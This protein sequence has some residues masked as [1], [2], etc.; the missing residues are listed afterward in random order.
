[1]RFH[2]KGPVVPMGFSLESEEGTRPEWPHFACAGDANGVGRG[3][4]WHDDERRRACY[5]SDRM[6]AASAK[7]V[8]SA[9]DDGRELPGIDRLLA[10]AELREEG[11]AACLRR[12]FPD[13][14]PRCGADHWKRAER[15]L[16]AVRHVASA[17]IPAI[18]AA[19]V[20]EGLI[21]VPLLRE[22]GFQVPSDE[23]KL[24]EMLAN[25]NLARKVKR[26]IRLRNNLPVWVGDPARTKL[27]QIAWATQY[28]SKRIGAR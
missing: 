23:R 20:P 15:A 25:P 7:T 1:M 19:H 6:V 27:A 26:H 12:I 13:P 9:L 4:A 5:S 21:R 2:D 11:G 10:I 22:P 14:C 17:A 28:A 16:L 24:K 18:R 8:S 3:W